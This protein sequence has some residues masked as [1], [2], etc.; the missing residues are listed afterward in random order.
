MTDQTP[1]FMI[2]FSSKLRCGTFEPEYDYHV[3]LCKLDDGRYAV[4]FDYLTPQTF[5]PTNEVTSP[6]HRRWR[7]LGTEQA[8][9]MSCE[10]AREWVR[11]KVCRLFEDPSAAWGGKTD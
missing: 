3:D 4:Y 6:N 8:A 11:E 7:D 9:W 2:R 5:I 10:L 1:T